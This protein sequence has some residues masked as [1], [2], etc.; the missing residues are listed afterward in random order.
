VSFKFQHKT[1]ML[2]IRRSCS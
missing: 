1:A 2:E